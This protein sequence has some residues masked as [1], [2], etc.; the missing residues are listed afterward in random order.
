MKKLIFCFAFIASAAVV[1]PAGIREELFGDVPG[2]PRAEPERVVPERIVPERAEPARPEFAEPRPHVRDRDE[3]TVVF[4]RAEIEFDFRR[5]YLANEAQ[6]YTAIFQGLFSYHPITMGPVPAV[7]ESFALSED[8]KQ[9]TFFLRQNANF[10][11]GDPVTAEDFRAAW[12]SILDPEREAPY[13]SLF[14][15]IEGA[16]DFRMGLLEDPGE[17]GIIAAEPKKLVV[18]LNHP[19]SFFPSMLSHHAFSPIHPSM[20]DVEDWSL[21]P[22]ISNGPFRVYEADEDRI[23]FVRSE[24]YWGAHNVLL[25]RIIIRF[26]DTGEEASALWNSGEARWISGMVDID[27]LTDRSGIQ[28]NPIFATHYYFIRSAE[29]PWNDYRVRRALVLALPWEQIR[30]GHFL[31]ATRFIYPLPGYPD[32][33]GLSVTDVERSEALLSEAGFPGG[34]GLPELVIRITPST[35]AA[36]IAGIMAYAWQGLGVSVRVEIV[37]FAYYFESL[38]MEGFTVGSLTW[39]GDFADPYSFLKLF[40]RDSN[41]N[42][43]GHSDDDFEALME[44]SMFEEGETRWATLAEAEQ[45]L[46]YRGSVIPISFSFA[47]NIVDLNELE[48]WFPNAL[49]IHPFKYL[50]FREFRPLPGVVMSKSTTSP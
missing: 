19:A 44:R 3:L 7:A 11:N 23:V 20:L 17:V 33:E 6:L 34:E 38:R 13:A 18:R 50:S 15:I 35:D 8:R 26:V 28:V 1:F 47:V 10:W 9:W 37:P 4:S 40:R 48:G 5:S 31:P 27:A 32:I 42:Y 12:L 29:E 30:S 41:I 49:G 14:D 45:L 24:E 21:S 39:I 2:V 16:R 43:A 46:L 22:P 25:N 36:R